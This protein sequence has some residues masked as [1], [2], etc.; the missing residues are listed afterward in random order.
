MGDWY[1]LGSIPIT[2][3]GFS[4]AGAHNAVESYELSDDGTIWTTYTFRKNS[5]DGPERRFT[6]K[7]WVHD[8]A[9]N[10]EWRMQFVWPFKAAYL[11]AWVD[12]AYSEAIIGVPSRSNVWLLSR[13]PN[14][15]EDA[16]QRLL[17]RTAAFGYDPN[18]IQ[19]VPQRW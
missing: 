14:P 7:G 6:P 8:E 5:F 2:F 19:R 4:E 11:I 17:E 1:V 3:P 10:T 12:E 15:T 16:Y 18:A 9:T 13:E